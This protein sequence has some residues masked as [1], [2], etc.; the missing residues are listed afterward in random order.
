VRKE[1]WIRKNM[2]NRTLGGDWRENLGLER[3][4]SKEGP[5]YDIPDW[6][7]ADGR[8]G[9]PRLSLF[10]EIMLIKVYLVLKKLQEWWK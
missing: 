2:P 10:H 5:L 9:I 6:S 8:P 4:P 3:N 1:K 7:Y